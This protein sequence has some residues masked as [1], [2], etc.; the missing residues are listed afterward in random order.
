MQGKQGNLSMVE[1]GEFACLPL[2]IFYIII[3]E[4]KGLRERDVCGILRTD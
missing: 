2:P 4:G 3:I 1:D